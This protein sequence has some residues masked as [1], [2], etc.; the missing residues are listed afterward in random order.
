[1]P[2]SPLND[3]LVSARSRRLAMSSMW[4]LRILKFI[5]LKS[6]HVLVAIGLDSTTLQGMYQTASP[7]GLLRTLTFPAGEGC[8]LVQRSLLGDPA[9]TCALRARATAWARPT[10]PPKRG[11]SPRSPGGEPPLSH[12]GSLGAIK[13]RRVQELLERRAE[14]PGL[15]VPPYT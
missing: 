8:P 3:V 10:E 9:M 4:L 14:T 1:M 6:S 12:S 5:E 7:L 15:K 2:Q 13:N 11:A